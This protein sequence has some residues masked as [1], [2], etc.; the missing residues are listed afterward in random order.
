MIN[1]HSPQ[2]SITVGHRTEEGRFHV[3]VSVSCRLLKD[4]RLD[5]FQIFKTSKRASIPRQATFVF[6]VLVLNMVPSITSTI[7]QLHVLHV[8]K[9]IIRSLV[10]VLQLFLGQSI[11][12]NM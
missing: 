3:F 12:T 9:V 4:L 2:Q 8:A 11:S 6:G 1:L 5:R 10:M 7:H